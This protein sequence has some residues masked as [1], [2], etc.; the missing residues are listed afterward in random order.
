MLVVVVVAVVMRGSSGPAQCGRLCSS[1]PRTHAC[2]SWFH[3][4][5]FG[6][7]LLI[8]QVGEALAIEVLRGDS[9][10]VLSATLEASS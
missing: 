4:L 1:A 10:Q 9:K 3:T 6:I 2:C 8:V 5:F 7:L